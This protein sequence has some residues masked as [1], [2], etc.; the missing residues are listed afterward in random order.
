MSSECVHGAVIPAILLCLEDLVMP[1]LAWGV[2]PWHLWGLCRNSDLN[3]NL[4]FH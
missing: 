2:G 4:Y 3:K 1:L